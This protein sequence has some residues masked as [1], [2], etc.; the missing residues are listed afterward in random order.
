MYVMVVEDMLSV[1]GSFS[2][3][4]LS[5]PQRSQMFSLSDRGELDSFMA[6]MA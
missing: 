1:S 5:L 2:V 4:N 6:V 3:C